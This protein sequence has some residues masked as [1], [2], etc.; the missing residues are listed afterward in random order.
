MS[1]EFPEMDAVLATHLAF[2]APPPI[3]IHALPDKQYLEA[4]ILPLLVY[5]LEATAR[6]R[7]QDPLEFLAAYLVSNNPQRDEVL[8]PPVHP[9]LYGAGLS[10]VN[11]VQALQKA[12]TNGNASLSATAGTA[13]DGAIIAGPSPPG[14]KK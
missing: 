9:L 1:S 2:E 13:A 14:S 12:E 10:V 4:T 6:E 3:P 11:A 7:P 5:G 8:P